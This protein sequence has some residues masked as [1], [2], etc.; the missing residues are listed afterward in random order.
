MVDDGNLQESMEEISIDKVF[1][2]NG[3]NNVVVQNLTEYISQ[4][5]RSELTNDY[6]NLSE[7]VKS[8]VSAMRET[9][10]SGQSDKKAQ[11]ENAEIPEYVKYFVLAELKFFSS[12]LLEKY[13]EQTYTQMPDE[14][15]EV[16][17]LVN[18]RLK[19]IVGEERLN[20]FT[21]NLVVKM[22]EY[23]QATVSFYLDSPKL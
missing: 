10:E 5:I 6:G 11:I 23:F 14:Y 2:V 1:E 13:L 20:A 15:D 18:E 4:E 19:S 17:E 9:P 8:Y 21:N 12:E 22:R 3:G 7:K 16:L